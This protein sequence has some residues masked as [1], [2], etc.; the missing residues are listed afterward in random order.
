MGSDRR[1]GPI[2][3]TFNNVRPW[4]KTRECTQTLKTSIKDGQTDRQTQIAL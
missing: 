4:A 2:R 3:I 1:G